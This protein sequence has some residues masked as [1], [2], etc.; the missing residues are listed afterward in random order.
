MSDQSKPF[1]Y[2]I[3]VEGCISTNWHEWFG[4]MQIHQEHDT[5]LLRGQ[6]SDISAVY[7]ILNRLAGL[8]LP[9]I[10]VQRIQPD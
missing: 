6:L 8:N 2:L 7:G 1:T 4:E 5:T 10:S 3:R 9:L